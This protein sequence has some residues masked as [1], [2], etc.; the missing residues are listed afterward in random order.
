MFPDSILEDTI[1]FVDTFIPTWFEKGS[2]N[3]LFIFISGPQGS[4]KTFTAKKLFDHLQKQYGK[5][6]NIAY[7]SLDSFYLTHEDQKTLN[8]QNKDNKLLQGRGLPGTHDFALMND[9][10]LGILHGKGNSADGKSI[11]LPIYDKSK[12]NGEG[13]RSEDIYKVDV[14]VDIFLLEGW[15]LGFNPILDHSDEHPLLQGDMKEINAKLFM[16]ADLIWNNPEINSLGIVF[17]T[18]EIKNVYAWRKEQE[19]ETILKNGSGLTDL[20]VEKF[21]DRYMPCYEVYYDDFLRSE[22]LGSIATLTVGI[23]SKRQVYS[24]KIRCIE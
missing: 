3:P 20:Q 24:K 8:V 11:E 4:G 6:K 12:F 19:H 22:R 1:E 7:A 18:D 10:L 13:D 15:F 23:D 9:C 21:V 5:E 2:K 17:G 16:Y 14:P